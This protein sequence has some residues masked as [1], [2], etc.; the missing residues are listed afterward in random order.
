MAALLLNSCGVSGPTSAPVAG[1]NPAAT[2]NLNAFSSFPSGKMPKPLPKWLEGLPPASVACL[3][4]NPNLNLN[5]TGPATPF[6]QMCG[7]YYQFAHFHRGPE[8][9]W[10][11]YDTGGRRYLQ[12][13]MGGNLP[14]GGNYF[15]LIANTT[16]SYDFWGR[17][18]PSGAGLP[19]NPPLVDYTIDCGDP[20]M[21][22][23]QFP[24][25]AFIDTGG[26][27]YPGGGA[28]PIPSDPTKK[29]ELVAVSIAPDTASIAIGSTAN[30]TATAYYINVGPYTEDITALI[31]SGNPPVATITNG[32]VT[33]L[34][35]GQ[36]ILKV[37]LGGFSAISIVDVSACLSPQPRDTP[38]LSLSPHRRLVQL[39][40][41]S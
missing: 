24:N 21:K 35:P 38:R 22:G 19:P 40:G 1:T 12:Y 34:S 28:P 13:P 36:S 18:N 11:D 6:D 39:Q 4:S 10:I 25:D 30:F 9:Y 8:T 17:Y 15:I 29:R 37:T 41:D 20:C 32:L 31:T 5:A 14:Y 23:G 26:N 16:A 27:I 7:N 33:G 2:K 3:L